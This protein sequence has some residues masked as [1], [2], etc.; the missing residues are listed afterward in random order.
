[1]VNNLTFNETLTASGKL[2]VEAA[3]SAGS[4]IPLNFRWG[5]GT[6]V[7]SRRLFVYLTGATT[8]TFANDVVV[9]LTDAAGNTG[10]G[11]LLVDSV[12]SNIATVS[13][14]AYTVN[15]TG[16][17]IATVPYGTSK[18]VFLAA[19]TK[20]Q[21][22]QTWNDAG[23]ASTVANGNTLVVTAQ[24]G[25][26][27]KTYTITVA[28]PSSGGGGGGMAPTRD[29]CPLGDF[30]ASIYDGTCGTSPTGTG[31]TQSGT[32]LSGSTQPPVIPV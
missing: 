2:A 29:T 15:N 13:S 4:D 6:G 17:T 14:T 9:T 27:T 22:D 8:A 1:L 20:D 11:L 31:A 24:D 16:S 3:L 7:A 26:T 23:I 10:T 28:A 18:T 21:A 32:T 12:S 19:L 25:T 30:S 5:G